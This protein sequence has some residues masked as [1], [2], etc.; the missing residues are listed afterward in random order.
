MNDDPTMKGPDNEWP[1]KLPDGADQPQ[2]KKEKRAFEEIL[3][4]F[5]EL[6]VDELKR[7]KERFD[8]PTEPGELMPPMIRH[9]RTFPERTIKIL[10]ADTL[11][12]LEEK[13]N[14]YLHETPG[15]HSDVYPQRIER[16]DDVGFTMMLDSTL[17][18]DHDDDD[19]LEDPPGTMTAERSR[20]LSEFADDIAGSQ[21][22]DVQA[23]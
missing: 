16:F 18:P 5:M 12:G 2:P 9:R 22:T 23:D 10:S 1:D 3:G 7:Q 20:E 8:V 15:R 21:G 13:V 4:E 14:A 19:E 17:W 6:Y 11:Q